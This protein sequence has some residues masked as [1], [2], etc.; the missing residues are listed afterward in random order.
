[1]KGY[2][3]L[4][5]QTLAHK[6]GKT[7]YLR[8]YEED[9]GWGFLHLEETDCIDKAL[10]MNEKE[11]DDL[12]NTLIRHDKEWCVYYIEVERVTEII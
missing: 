3:A 6:E 7:F 5:D 9:W 1:M 8:E 11:K 2:I 10:L 12:E 4:L